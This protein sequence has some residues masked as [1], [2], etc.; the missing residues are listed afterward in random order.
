MEYF[1]WDL[2]LQYGERYEIPAELLARQ[3]RQ[4]SG[5]NPRAIGDGGK[6]RGL[7]QFWEATWKDVMG[8]DWD[9]AFDPER[10]I[11]AMAKYDRWLCDVIEAKTELRGKESLAWALRAYNWGIGN[12]LKLLG[13]IP[14]ATQRYGTLAFG[15]EAVE[16]L[17]L[18]G[19]LPRPGGP[20]GGGWD[21]AARE[22]ARLVPLL[23]ELKR[24]RFG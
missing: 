24:R 17:I 4:E 15:G 21:E 9:E 22:N 13:Q 11:E 19:L 10:A 20:K 16:E 6:A 1:L 3:C 7:G 5:F 2:F 14:Q 12:V 8:T 23:V 18:S